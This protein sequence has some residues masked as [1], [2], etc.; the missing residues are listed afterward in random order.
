MY[1]FVLQ[2]PVQW[3]LP[4]LWLFSAILKYN[5]S[6]LCT[7][8]LQCLP[9]LLYLAYFV[10][11]YL[12]IY[13]VFSLNGE[14]PEKAET[15]TLPCPPT[16]ATCRCSINLLYK[17]KKKHKTGDTNWFIIATSFAV[18]G[19]KAHISLGYEL[20]YSVGIQL[21]LVN[22]GHMLCLLCSRITH[23]ALAGVA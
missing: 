9:S 5:W 18:H 8:T 2:D 6:L 21:V 15:I 19:S 13:L 10:G 3:G 7:I 20:S 23:L 16:T 22:S 17:W 14:L 1:D 11:S 12:F 4:F